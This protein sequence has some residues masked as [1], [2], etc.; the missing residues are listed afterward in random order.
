MDRGLEHMR[1]AAP[2][3]NVDAGAFFC[4]VSFR[5]MMQAIRVKKCSAMV[6]KFTGL[7]L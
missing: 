1:D 4:L 3:P 7:Y 5:M 2:V 6:D